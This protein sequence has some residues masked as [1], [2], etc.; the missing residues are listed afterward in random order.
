MRNKTLKYSKDDFGQAMVNA[1]YRHAPHKHIKCIGDKMTFSGFWRDGQKRNVCIWPKEAAWSDLHQSVSG[2]NKG[3]VTSFAKTVLNLDLHDFMTQYGHTQAKPSAIKKAVKEFSADYVN[4]IWTALVTRNASKI[5][6]AKNWLMTARKLP[7]PNRFIG[8]GFTNLN[9][10]DVELFDEEHRGLIR[11]RIELGHNIVVPLRGIKNDKVEN[12]FIRTI[13]A[14]SKENKSRLLTGCGGW[15]GVKDSPRAFGFPHLIHEF[16]NL[17]ICEGMADYFAAEC[18]LDAD[19]KY[20]PIGAPGTAALHKWAD[21][22]SQT[23]YSGRIHIVYQLDCDQNGNLANYG[24]GQQAA[25][26]AKKVLCNAGRYAHLFQW[27]SFLQEV[28]DWKKP[29]GDLADV[30][31]CSDVQPSI[32]SKN[33]LHTLT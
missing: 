17:I 5:D 26:V 19:E 25:V 28:S 21:W 15:A 1:V 20:L 24:P 3:G 27:T 14:V 33:F 13:N 2:T 32:L 11:K 18:L 10:S 6:H 31:T 29:P 8:S 4:E 22:L 30:F 7:E 9:Q 23:K 16:P 12:L